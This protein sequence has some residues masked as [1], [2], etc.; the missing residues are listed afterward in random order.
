VEVEEA[1]AGKETTAAAPSAPRKLLV[2]VFSGGSGAV[3]LETMDPLND[4]KSTQSFSAAELRA[5]GVGLKNGDGLSEQE[6]MLFAWCLSCCADGTV[7]LLPEN[8]S[9]APPAASRKASLDTSTA[10]ATWPF[11]GS[12]SAE[13]SDAEHAALVSRVVSAAARLTQGQVPEGV[14]RHAT[15]AVLAPPRLVS[16]L[17]SSLMSTLAD[18]AAA[19]TAASSSSPRALA[20]Q[21]SRVVD[22]IKGPLYSRPALRGPPGARP[23]TTDWNRMGAR[24]KA[25]HRPASLV[26]SSVP[27]QEWWRPPSN[28]FALGSTL[29]SAA[30]GDGATRPALLGQASAGKVYAAGAAFVAPG[31][32]EWQPRTPK[33]PPLD[34][35]PFKWGGAVPRGCMSTKLLAVVPKGPQSSE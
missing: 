7:A 4:R 14:L 32:V 34:M 18:A 11:A 10:V 9:K 19:E 21:R 16:P 15:C 17:L 1:A 22:S 30:R 29:G 25:G 20:L 27:S 24:P 13:V 12:E 33:L 28:A 3:R 31:A 23:R 2:E 5:A 26:W 6:A 35:Q 8:A